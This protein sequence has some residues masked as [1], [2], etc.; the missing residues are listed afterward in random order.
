MVKKIVAS[1]SI[2]KSKSCALRSGRL[3][4]E[5]AIGPLMDVNERQ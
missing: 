3:F 1:P 5:K 2:F 4:G